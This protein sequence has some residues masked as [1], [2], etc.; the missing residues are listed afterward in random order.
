MPVIPVLGKLRQEDCRFKASLHYIENSTV[1][2]CLKR[3][4][5][6]RISA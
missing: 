6:W 2:P 1:T 3:K 4:E 5:I